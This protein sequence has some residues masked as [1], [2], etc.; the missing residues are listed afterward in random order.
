MYVGNTIVSGNKIASV[1]S[2]SLATTTAS[3][4]LEAY[5]IWDSTS[6]KISALQH[7]MYQGGTAVTEAA[8]TNASIVVANL[9]GL[10]FC[11]SATNGSSVA[12]T[13]FTLTAF[14]LDVW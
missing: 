3:G 13:T 1:T 11:I 2:G 9:A 12:G 10:Q 6:T 14:C 7:G 8:A 4:W 5:G